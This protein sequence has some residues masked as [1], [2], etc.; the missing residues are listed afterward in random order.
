MA[1]VKLNHINLT[2]IPNESIILLISQ[3]INGNSTLIKTILDTKPINTGYYIASYNNNDIVEG[4][5]RHLSYSKHI[6]EQMIN[7][8]VDTQINSAIIFDDSLD[9]LSCIKDN[10]IA[11]LFYNNKSLKQLFIMG[12]QYPIAIP[13]VLR[14]NIDFIFVNNITLISTRK[15]FMNSMAAYLQHL[16]NLIRLLSN[17]AIILIML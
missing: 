15:K 7:G 12:T 11:P 9:M 4:N 3:L 14:N 8:I 10:S 2:S 17:M 1:N 13:P 16:R 5:G 6:N